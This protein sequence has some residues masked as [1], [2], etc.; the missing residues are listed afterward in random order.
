[1]L[2]FTSAPLTVDTKIAGPIEARI[3]AASSA[4]DTDF[5]VRLLDVHP[6]GRAMNITEGI[7]R[8][9]FRN[10]RAS[11]PSLITPG[12]TYDYTVKLLPMSIV[13]KKGHCIRVQLTSSCFPLWDRNP[14][15]GHPIGMSAEM[16]VANQTI[17][18][19]SESPSHIA[20]PVIPA[21]VK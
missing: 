11:P 4:R 1:M 15:T 14:N 5:V 21:S 18:H 8:A 2:V 6:D 10:G 17:Y 16:Q 20:L 13:L 19:D 7:V 9:R 12:E 3:H